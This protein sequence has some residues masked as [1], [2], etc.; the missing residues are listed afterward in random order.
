MHLVIFDDYLYKSF[1]PASQLRSVGDIRCGVLK[2]RQRLT[3]EL[4]FEDAAII[5]RPGLVA[6]YRYRQSSWRI[7][8]NPQGLKL[9]VNSRISLDDATIKLIK[10]IKEGEALVV[11]GSIVAL[12]TEQELSFGFDSSGFQERAVEA[13]L[14]YNMVDI[15]HDNGR[16]IMRDFENIFYEE[17]NFYETEPGV[18]VLHPYNVWIGEGAMLAPN[19]VL[20]AS[21]GAIIID[22]EARIMAN[23]VI[24]G[25]AYIGKKSVVKIGAKVY[26]GS[27]IGPVCKVGG[28]IESS[29][30]Q[31]YSNKQHDG[32][33]G[34]SYVGEWVNLG[35]DT[36]N[37]DLKNNYKNVFQYNYHTDKLEDSGTQFMGSLIADHVKIG[38]NCSLNTGLVVGLGANIYGNKLFSGFVP[39]FSWGEADALNTYRL[40]EFLE[41]VGKV[42][43]RRKLE[44]Q[45]IESELLKLFHG[46]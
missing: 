41:T 16:M 8:D 44:L 36:N 46:E 28:E 4:G 20:D 35:A 37:S 3:Y 24:V 32:F 10:E 27:S 45:Q 31:A 40:E 9:Y 19:V 7:N 38:I 39:D 18:H 23:A 22:E 15:V 21:E 12:L 42:K 43:S 2:L 5:V 33:L 34:H 11:G 6:L 26:G 13:Q 17:D 30:F 25:P 14:Y 1:Y 29:I